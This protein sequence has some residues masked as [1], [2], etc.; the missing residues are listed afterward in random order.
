MPLGRD[1]RAGVVV[2]AQMLVGFQAEEGV[3]LIE[4]AHRHKAN[5]GVRPLDDGVGR[6]DEGPGYRGRR[7]LGRGSV[8][9]F[10]LI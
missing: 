7:H 2:E 8:L 6:D 3:P 10:H 1:R 5:I 9:V 4:I